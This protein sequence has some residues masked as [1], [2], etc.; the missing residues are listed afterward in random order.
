MLNDKEV[1]FDIQI[2][3]CPTACMHCYAN[4]GYKSFMPFED[5]KWVFDNAVDYFEKNNMKFSPNLFHEMYAHPDIAKIQPMV[6]KYCISGGKTNFDP[7]TTTGVPFAIRDDWREIMSVMKDIGIKFF[8]FTFHG[9]GEKHDRM[10]NRVGAFEETCLAVKRAKEMGFEWGCNVML[11]KH[12]IEDAGELLKVFDDLG[13]DRGSSWDPIYYYPLHRVRKLEELRPELS[14][15]LRVSDL[16]A[17]KS[18]WNG[19]AWAN[20]SAYTES[21]LYAK[22]V[23]STS[24]F[25][26]L[27]ETGSLVNLVCTEG[28]D[29]YSGHGNILKNYYGNLK[30]DGVSQV[31][32]KA[33]KEPKDKYRLS[34]YFERDSY[35]PIE[36]LA[37]K[38]GDPDGQKIYLGGD[39]EIYQ[40]WIDRYYTDYRRY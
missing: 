1:W 40:C 32:D 30:R 10:V 15:V 17:E 4:G 34:I 20:P 29:V 18:R 5:F 8:W 14:D 7:A 26:K 36:E 9:L 6:N 39:W 37:S 22:A 33:I 19:A 25:K 12:T 2:S 23:K 35:L 24:E 3:G 11:Y 27:P 31:L 28:M 21:S 16:L 13:I 38:V